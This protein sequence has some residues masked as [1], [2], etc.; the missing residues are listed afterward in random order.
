[1]DVGRSGERPPLQE[2]IGEQ[3]QPRRRGLVQ[4]LEIVVSMCAMF[5]DIHTK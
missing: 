4:G 5:S 2:E 1:M 3:G